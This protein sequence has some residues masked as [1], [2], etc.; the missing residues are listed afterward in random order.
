MDIFLDKYNYIAKC[1][2]HDNYNVLLKERQM[3][4]SEYSCLPHIWT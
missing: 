4:T 2:G 1:V 3:T